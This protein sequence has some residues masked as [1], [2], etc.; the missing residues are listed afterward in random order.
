VSDKARLSARK[1]EPRS[2]E[3]LVGAVLR[4]IDAVG[5]RAATADPDSAQHLRLI[6]EQLDAATVV[7]VRGWR[8]AGFS[9]S[10]IGR[11]LGV[12]KQAVQQRWPRR[13]V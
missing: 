2:D 3:D 4:L 11:E 1:A 6:G 8:A 13:C 7:A 5:R 9:D 10:Q 12:T